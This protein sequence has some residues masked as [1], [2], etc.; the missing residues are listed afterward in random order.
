MT[1]I[2]CPASMVLTR[3]AI[4]SGFSRTFAGLT[5]TY[6][7]SIGSNGT[8]ALVVGGAAEAIDALAGEESAE[9]SRVRIPFQLCPHWYGIS[10][11]N[12]T[13]TAQAGAANRSSNRLAARREVHRCGPRPR[14]AALVL[15][16]RRIEGPTAS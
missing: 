3:A 5:A 8:P 4:T 14:H 9:K 15:R 2:F 12:G 10:S 1:L 7:S 13:S 6:T 16:V 11:V